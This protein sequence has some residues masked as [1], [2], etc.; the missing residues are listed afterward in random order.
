MPILSKGASQDSLYQR[1]MQS[2]AVQAPKPQTVGQPQPDK[3]PAMRKQM[4]LTG[5][6][7]LN[8]WGEGNMATGAMSGAMQGTPA[9]FAGGAYGA[10]EGKNASNPWEAFIAGGKGGVENTYSN[11]RTAVASPDPVQTFIGGGAGGVAAFAGIPNI[12][13]IF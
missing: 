3:G 2:S 4:A 6:G 8:A 11:W 5:E 13:K 7:P 1:A 12:T 10:K 9:G